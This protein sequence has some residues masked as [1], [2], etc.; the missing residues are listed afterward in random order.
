MN[1]PKS[2][3][4]DGQKIVVTDTYNDRILIWNNFPTVN[5]QTADI[6][7]QGSDTGTKLVKNNLLWPWG[8]WTDGDKLAITST[9]QGGVLIWN[10]FP[11]RDNESADIKLTGNGAM[12][13]PRQITSDGNSLIIGDHNASIDGERGVGTFF[14]KSFP[15]KDE[16]PYDFYMSDPIDLG[17]GAPWMRGDF[18]TDGKL[19]VLGSALY[20]WDSFP[21]DSNS[22]PTLTVNGGYEK[23]GASFLKAT[24]HTDLSIA[25][26]K[27]FLTTDYHT[28]SVYNSIPTSSDQKPD[29][30][31]GGPDIYTNAL[32]SNDFMFNPIPATD[33]NSLFVVSDLSLIH[34]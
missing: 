15:D 33:G 16:Q 9:K 29:F 5:G 2:I 21:E 27:V 14:W 28:I 4:T 3:A 1:W 6:V 30:V 7:L 19:L 11:T 13:T 31:I 12:G 22:S 8:V 10:D 26:D 25:G 20:L 23:W 34:I 18:N 17:T 24:D 32:K